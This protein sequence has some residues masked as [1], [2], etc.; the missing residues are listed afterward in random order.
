[1]LTFKKYR[2]SILLASFHILIV[3]ASN[4]LVQF[5]INI[6]G[7]KATW[8]AFTFP[9][10]FLATDLTVRL[11]GAQI[12]GKV[13]LY[14]MFPALVVSYLI[15]N[16]FRGGTWLGVDQLFSFDLFVARI[17]IASFA[18]YVIG[19]LI[20]VN[21]FNRLR[22]SKTWWYAPV[23]S[24]LMGNLID[25]YAFFFIA[26]YKTSD[27]YLAKNWV[28]IATV[29]YFFKVLISS[30]FFLPLYK[31]LLNRLVKRLKTT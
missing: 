24:T 19:Q 12:G 26:F 29:D 28:E 27:V 1:M 21:I 2:L 6:F 30:I 15:T 17:A 16:G 7:F 4:Y 11:L 10:I 5:P 9:F 25:T 3:A 13:I 23:A 14:A 20:D 18:A 31:I 8:G 22:Q